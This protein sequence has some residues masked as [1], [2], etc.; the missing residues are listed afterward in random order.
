MKIVIDIPDGIYAWLKDG[1]SDEFDRKRLVKAVQNGTPLT[2]LI[3]DIKTEK[4]GDGLYDRY[5]L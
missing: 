4:E 2:E 1:Y 3:E 5:L